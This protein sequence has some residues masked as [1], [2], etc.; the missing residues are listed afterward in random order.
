LFICLQ[1]L[2]MVFGLDYKTAFGCLVATL[3][4]VGVGVGDILPN[5]AH[6]S[7]P[8]KMVLIVAMLAGR[9][10]IFTLL[11]LFVPNYWRK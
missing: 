5:F 9:L 3:A 2:L 11:V 4:N 8:C 10:E 6:L 7:H 1:L